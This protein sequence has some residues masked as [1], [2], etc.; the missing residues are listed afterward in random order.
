MCAASQPEAKHAATALYAD[1]LGGA[2]AGLRRLA[3][4]ARPLVGIDRVIA[5]R[6]EM[7]HRVGRRSIRRSRNQSTFRTRIWRCT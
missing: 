7:M 5:L 6:W 4:A 2:W 3:V 1:A